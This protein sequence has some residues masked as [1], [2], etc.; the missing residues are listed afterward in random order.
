[1]TPQIYQ[2]GSAAVSVYVHSFYFASN[3]YVKYLKHLIF[4]NGGGIYKNNSKTMTQ[5]YS[6]KQMQQYYLYMTNPNSTFFMRYTLIY[7][8]QSGN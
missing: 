5:N 1:M 6:A 2:A 4:R 8:C 3:R 7:Q